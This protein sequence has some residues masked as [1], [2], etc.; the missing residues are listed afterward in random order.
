MDRAGRKHLSQIELSLE[1]G[2]QIIAH[3]QTG[4]EVEGYKSGF[5]GVLVATDRRLR[6]RGTKMWGSARVHDEFYR[7]SDIRALSFSSVATGAAHGD[8]T[9]GRIALNAAGRQRY[10]QRY[11]LVTLPDDAEV[12][13]LVE[14]AQ[15]RMRQLLADADTS[16]SQTHLSAPEVLLRQLASLHKAGVLTDDEFAAKKTDVLGRM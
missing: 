3:L 9:R 15:E 12:K 16:Q 2:E 7:Y 11:G 4:T 14:A 1:P 10:F 13:M 6:F 8:Q 5:S